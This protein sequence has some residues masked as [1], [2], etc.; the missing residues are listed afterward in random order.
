MKWRLQT[1]ETLPST[2]DVCIKAAEAGEPEGLAILARRQTSG[3]GTHGRLWESPIGNLYLSVLLRPNEPAS[4]AGLW[5]LL[6][7]VA[8][9]EALGAGPITFKWPNDLMIGNAKLAGILLE[10]AGGNERLE[11]LVIGFGANLATAPLVPGR[12][13]ASLAAGA[14][15]DVAEA[16]LSRLEVWRAA[17][18]AAARSAWLRAAQNLGNTIK[19]SRPELEGRFQGIA[20]DGALLLERPE[21]IIRVVSGEVLAGDHYAS[22]VLAQETVWGAAPYP[23]RGRAP[24]PR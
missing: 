3:R 4:S 19:L 1:Y 5:S 10:S 14:V 8:L 24:G 12:E 16:L 20:A 15:E 23:A 6:A 13:T 7:A 11:W 21:G 2:S 17:G 9:R 22:T 18:L